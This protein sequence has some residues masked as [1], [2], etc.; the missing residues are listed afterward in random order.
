M[1][2]QQTLRVPDQRTDAVRETNLNPGT[3]TWRAPCVHGQV[4]VT[5]FRTQLT[6]ADHEDC[7]CQ[8][9]P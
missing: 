3:A 5:W 1:R 2:R 8:V 6:A 7:E 9:A 4:E